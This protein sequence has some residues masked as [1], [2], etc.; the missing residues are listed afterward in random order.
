[1]PRIYAGLR[2]DTKMMMP[3]IWMMEVMIKGFE[4]LLYG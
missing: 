1:M 2:R 4:D 3:E